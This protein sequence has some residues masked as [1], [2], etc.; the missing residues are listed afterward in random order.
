[1]S[2][3]PICRE[4][5]TELLALLTNSRAAKP[6]YASSCI[7]TATRDSRDDPAL[8][9][10]LVASAAGVLD[11]ENSR[12]AGPPPATLSPLSR[13]GAANVAARRAT[14][15]ANLTAAGA[16]ADKASAL[17]GSVSG[18]LSKPRDNQLTQS[19]DGFNRLVAAAPADFLKNPPTYFL[20][21][22]AV[23]A[24]LVGD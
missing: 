7:S 8:R 3:A 21:V 10:H 22:H 18:I 19:I 2:G 9:P 23:L 11:K 1:V 17:L 5:Q 15:L 4:A 16:P 13:E 14:I 24:R 12:F 6:A 20:A